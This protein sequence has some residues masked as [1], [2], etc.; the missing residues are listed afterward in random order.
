MEEAR[1]E[2]A[3]GEGGSSSIEEIGKFRADI[4]VDESLDAS[5]G[6]IS[7]IT[8]EILAAKSYNNKCSHV[9]KDIREFLPH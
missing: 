1:D 8:S 2:A 9:L 5:V 3:V 4:L 7:G 6:V